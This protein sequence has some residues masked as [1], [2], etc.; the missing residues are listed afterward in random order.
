MERSPLRWDGCVAGESPLHREIPGVARARR[1]DEPLT[2][3]VA[4]ALS[5][6]PRMLVATARYCLPFGLVGTEAV[7][8]VPVVT[9]LY[10]DVS[11]RFAHPWGG[12]AS[13]CHW[14]VG[15]GVPVAA[16]EKVAVLPGATLT[17]TGS[18]VNEG[19][20]D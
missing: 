8:S 16:A 15:A 6:V 18:D 5:A 19:G 12:I 14:T 2:V 1:Q 4:A 9:P 7:I 13:T 11:D 20:L 10:G 3:S 17:E